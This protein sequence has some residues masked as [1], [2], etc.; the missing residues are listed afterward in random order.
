[1]VLPATVLPSVAPPPATGTCASPHTAPSP[2]SAREVPQANRDQPHVDDADLQAL[3]AQLGRAPR[4]VAAIAARCVCG[5]PL[6]AK[7]SPR[8]PDGAPFPTL[9]YLTHPAANRAIGSLESRGTMNALNRELKENGALAEAYQGAHRQYLAV[10]EQMALVKEIENISVGGMPERV[11][12]LHALAAH[13]LAEGPGVN[14]IGDWTLLAIA[15]EWRP[16]QCV[17]QDQHETG[18]KETSAM[19][20]REPDSSNAATPTR[21]GQKHV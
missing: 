8:L 5:A 15:H 7:T 18:H 2:V 1:M 10:R 11:K 13:A 17:C 9:Y 6:V 4:G 21:R 12:C 16:D 20:T 3:H 19:T 14:P